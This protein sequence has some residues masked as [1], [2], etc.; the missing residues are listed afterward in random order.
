MKKIDEEIKKVEND[1]KEDNI[2][3]KVQID[4]NTYLSEIF[5]IIK[6]YIDGAI[7][8]MSIQN[9]FFDANFELIAKLHKVIEK[10]IKNFLIILNKIDLSTNLNED[11]NKC[12]G[13][14]MK[15]FPSCKTFNINLNTF[16]PISTIQ[17]QNELLLDK[18]FKYLL[19]YHFYNYM[20]KINNE[21][22]IHKNIINK[23]FINHLKDIIKTEKNITR[24]DIENTVNEFENPGIDDEIIE[25]INELKDNFKANDIN[26][27]ITEQ[28]FLNNKN[29]TNNNILDLDME[30]TEDTTS[31]SENNN[32]DEI[33]PSYILKF[34]Y[35]Y[36][37]QNKLI[38]LLS[39]ETNMLLNYF[40]VKKKLPK[41]NQKSKNGDDLSEKTLINKRIIKN[42]KTIAKEIKKS[43]FISNEIINIINEI[44]K[45]VEFLRIYNVI[46]IPFLGP[47]NAGKTT[48]INGIIGEEVLPADLNECTK[49]GIIIRYLNDDEKEI[50]IRKAVFTEEE[51]LGKKKYYF[52]PKEVIAE[53]LKDVQDTVKGLNYNFT[54][55]EEDSFYYI[56]TKIKLFDDL[57]L[58][59]Y[60]KK[61]IYLIDF[62]GFGTGNIF[63]K[64]LYKKIMSICNSFV[65]VFRKSFIKEHKN[66][67][68]LDNIFR[69]A[70]NQKHKLSSG[71]IKNCLF[72]LNND[73]S[74]TT[75]EED[76]NYA[77]KD[78]NELFKIKEQKL[79]F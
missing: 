69:Q 37:T 45:T 61:M 55:K 58:D 44:Y 21:K 59:N 71:F 20:T 67:E 7:I 41:L 72:V 10:D 39:E 60:Y 73:N 22:L 34:L 38:P 24:A 33:N 3:Y 68:L 18:S 78:I 4:E 35:I 19:N 46:F 40:R 26:F 14:F 29:E 36:Q 62:P 79:F 47:S 56:R 15:H 28:D 53:G 49:R 77:K 48:I 30:L 2:F 63:E 52:D 76:I 25:I 13:L 12:K 27:G 17:L 50:N 32:F 64:T 31:G 74:Q 6:N 23:S 42:L 65:F 11:I 57:G 1:K 51:F 5:K 43:Q 16:V 70:R 9:Y 75:N 54:D 8:I 66:K